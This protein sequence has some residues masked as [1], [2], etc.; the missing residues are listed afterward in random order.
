MA[1]RRQNPRDTAK[2][3]TERNLLREVREESMSR[4]S[5][6]GIK[7]G[8]QLACAKWALILAGAAAMADPAVATTPSPFRLRVDDRSRTEYE[9]NFDGRTASLKTGSRE[10]R[11]IAFNACAKRK[12]AWLLRDIESYL[13]T[14]PRFAQAGGLSLTEVTANGARFYVLPF[15]PEGRFFRRLPGE[16]ELAAFQT[17]RAC[18]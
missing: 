16:F 9:L 17:Q 4:R 2:A 14:A 11:K 1:R 15:S 8:I 12:A 3:A 6:T 18:K 5:K 10:A 13:R 7:T